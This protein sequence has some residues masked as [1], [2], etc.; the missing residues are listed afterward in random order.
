MAR[1]S[2]RPDVS[3]QTNTPPHTHCPKA[4][5]ANYYLLRKSCHK[6]QVPLEEQ[7]SYLVSRPRPRKNCISSSTSGSLHCWRALSPLTREFQSHQLNDRATAAQIHQSAYR[8]DFHCTPSE[9]SKW[10]TCEDLLV[11]RQTHDAAQCCAEA[12]LKQHQIRFQ[13]QETYET[14]RSY[15]DAAPMHTRSQ[16][17]TRNPKFHQLKHLALVDKE[18]LGH[19]S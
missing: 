8:N 18:H 1:T 9:L 15:D 4:Y 14:P 7:R 19:E 13:R 17:R 2:R 16:Q 12:N 3:S 10:S 6:G 5:L 11:H